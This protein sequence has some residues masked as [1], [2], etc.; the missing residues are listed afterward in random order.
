VKSLVWFSD[1]LAV[2]FISA[3]DDKLDTGA[4][5]PTPETSIGELKVY[6]ERV[7]SL[8]ELTQFLGEV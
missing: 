1:F 5:V 6:L 7:H 4:R 3:T 8:I 2:A